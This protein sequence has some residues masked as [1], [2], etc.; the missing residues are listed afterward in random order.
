M[1]P[2]RCGGSSVIRPIALPWSPPADCGHAI[3]CSGGPPCCAHFTWIRSRLAAIGRL[4]LLKIAASASGHFES[5]SSAVVLSLVV[6][7]LVLVVNGVT[8]LAARR[9]R[10]D[11]A[12]LGLGI[13]TQE[14]LAPASIRIGTVLVSMGLAG[15]VVL[16]ILR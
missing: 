5:A 16:W 12:R 7:G 3:S 6:F 14:R 2:L 9:I 1:T 11:E 4:P 15:G 13:R 8:S 10:G